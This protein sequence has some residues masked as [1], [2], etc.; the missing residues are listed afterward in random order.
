MKKTTY[1]FRKLGSFLNIPVASRIEISL[2]CRR[3]LK[4]KNKNIETS[5]APNASA[6]TYIF[7][8]EYCEKKSYIVVN[9]LKEI[10]ETQVPISSIMKFPGCYGAVDPFFLFSLL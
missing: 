3:L 1:I 9:V 6:A 8:A 2:S 5:L 4:N 7:I 10:G